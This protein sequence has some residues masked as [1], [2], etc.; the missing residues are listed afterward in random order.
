LIRSRLKATALLLL[1]LL[2]TGCS[3]RDDTSRVVL[4][5]AL[6]RDFAEQ[7]LDVF[8]RR[9][10]LAVETKFDSEANKSVGLYEDLVREARHPRCDVH[11][12]NE[13]LATVRLQRQG[14]LEPYDSPSAAPYPTRYKARDHTWHAF[15]ARARVLLVNTDLVPTAERPRGLLELTERR[16]RGQVAMAAPHFGTSA[17]QAACLFQAWGRD[18]ARAFYLGL[19]ENGIR[20]VAGN[21][22]AAEGVGQGRFAVG[23]TDTDD[24]IAEVDAGRPVVIVYPDRGDDIGSGCGTLFIPNAVALIRGGPNPDGGRRLI[25]Y[26][27][28]AEVEAE[29]AGSASRQVPLNSKLEVRPAA[30]IETPRTVRELP[31]DFEAAAALWDEVQE[32]LAKEFARP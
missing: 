15:A 25:D 4:Y 1:V 19:R 11:W 12:N 16:W 10:G 20:L 30:P 5:C 24:A 23:L 32:F 9:T 29:L 26:L 14:L 6:D 8:H 3:G 17:T 7:A 18:K 27:L 13:I 2:P 22:Q 28:S 21:K 31:V